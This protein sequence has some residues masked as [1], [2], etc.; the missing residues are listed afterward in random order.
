MS[1]LSLLSRCYS[2]SHPQFRCPLRLQLSSS[3][4]LRVHSHF[5]FI[6]CDT[7]LPLS[8]GPFPAMV[9]SHQELITF[10]IL[11][12]L[13]RGR[14][15]R[16]KQQ[17]PDS[18]RLGITPG[19]SAVGEGR[20]NWTA[21]QNHLLIPAHVFCA[22]FVEVPADRKHVHTHTHTYIV[23]TQSLPHTVRQMLSSCLSHIS[24]TSTSTA[25]TASTP[26][27]WRQ[28]FWPWSELQG[29]SVGHPDLHP[30][31]HSNTH[32]HT[33]TDTHAYTL[34]YAQPGLNHSL[35]H[36]IMLQQSASKADGCGASSVP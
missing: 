29:F 10:I 21:S 8:S 1:S 22:F 2:V 36:N 14:P 24:W 5:C 6:F 19:P 11:C 18:G 32:R 33:H 27:P 26:S 28:T 23:S 12:V 31:N 7:C 4:N 30:S 9:K 25:L 16:L 13:I 34:L 20:E 15:F 35:T 17:T 3:P